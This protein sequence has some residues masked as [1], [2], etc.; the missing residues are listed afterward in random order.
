MNVVHISYAHL[1]NQYDPERWLDEIGFFTGILDCMAHEVSIKS[2]HCI[3]YNDILVRNGVEYH[4]LNIKAWQTFIP[5][6]MHTY[7]KKLNPDVVV[8]HGLIFPLQIILL[9]LSL[10]AHSKIVVQHHAERP[11][12]DLR[13]Y[14][15]K[16]ADRY[17]S[18]YFFC[19]IDLA[20]QWINRG[21]IKERKKIKE[22][23]EVS[24]SFYEVDK[25]TAKS[26]T[27]TS[28]EKVFIWVG[29]LHSRKD[30]LL[31]VRAFARFA[32]M[33]PSVKL[34]M[35]Y[36]SSELIQEVNSL[37]RDEGISDVIYLIGKVKHDELLYW[38]NSADFLVS[39][40]N[41]EGSGIAVCEAMSCGCIPL[42]SDIPS[43]RMMTNSGSVGL[44]FPVGDEEA[45][46][47]V[48]NQSLLL[49]QSAEK[50]KV[51][52]RFNN[53]LSF[54]AIAKKMIDVIH[55]II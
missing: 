48:L 9:R 29:G 13:Q 42:L 24:S 39:T 1:P 55:T 26:I 50:E 17:V 33:N 36:Q 19:S 8:V 31:M 2:I 53:A 3:S 23:M 45:L 43:F 40:S 5:L 28:G 20:D 18:A 6:K 14:L 21:L 54:Q 46:V 47:R 11:L 41:Y 49:D 25:E 32:R 38:F 12:K 27:K 15:Q 7:I 4:F 35:I 44:L 51:V 30:P 22:I 16:W 37:I 52:S 10:G 34:Y